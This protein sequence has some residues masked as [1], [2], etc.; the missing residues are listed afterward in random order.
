MQLVAEK[1]A[2]ERGGEIVF[3]DVSFQVGDGQALTITGPNGSG[4]STLLRIVAGLLE[5]AAGVIRLDGSRLEW[6][7][8]ASAAHYLGHGNS[9]KPALTVNE[10]LRFWRGFLGEAHLDVDEALDMVG[11]GDLGHL[12]FGYLSTG[13]RRRVA[14][15]RLVVSYRPLWLL[16]EPTSGLDRASEMQF[17]ALMQAHREEGG[18]IVAA[19]HQPLGLDDAVQLRL[20]GQ[21]QPVRETLLSS[22]M[23]PG[24]DP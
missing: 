10:N 24:V 19:T 17:T 7:T 3:S 5:P 8:I 13:Q 16:D 2:G 11:L 20:T 12:P 14:I 22:S 4:K 23:R 18:I 21:V 9:M 1:L 15:A 6:P